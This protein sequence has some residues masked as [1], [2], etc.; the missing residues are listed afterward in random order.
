[1]DLKTKP[2]T[3][4]ERI[5][6][7]LCPAIWKWSNDSAEG[8]TRLAE[9]MPA[10]G[11]LFLGSSL[12]AEAI[13]A[14]RER[15]HSVAGR[16]PIICMD[17]ENGPGALLAPNLDFPSPMAI[18]AAHLDDPGKTLVGVRAMGRATARYG[19]AAGC[20]WTLGPVVDLN[21]NP[22]N[23]IVQTRSF[24][25][26]PKC[27]DPSSESGSGNKPRGVD[28]PCICQVSE[29]SHFEN[30]FIRSAPRPNSES[31]LEQ[32]SECHVAHLRCDE[33]V[34]DGDVGIAPL[35]DGPDNG[36]HSPFSRSGGIRGSCGEKR[37]CARLRRW[38]R[39]P[40]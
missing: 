36:V 21:A 13:A 29:N 27:S 24:G 20:A 9:R 22:D 11:A 3:L 18:G 37:D 25:G 32:G 35:P 6:T 40:R 10:L 16:M 2:L 19:R 31:A 38:S 5:Q 14:V 7:I 33:A 8:I 15:F 4:D 17:L 12:D 30:P 34:V 26:D 39:T 23:P 1:M 28:P